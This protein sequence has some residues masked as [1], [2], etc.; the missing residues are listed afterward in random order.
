MAGCCDEDTVVR[1]AAGQRRTLLIVLAINIA[2]FAV[3]FTAGWIAASSALLADSLDMLGDALVYGFSLAVLQRGS[4]WKAVSAAVKGVVMLVFGLLVL[5]RTVDQVLTGG[6]PVSLII[7]LVALLA[8]AGN[9]LCLML[10]TRH[11]G[12]D[13]NMRSTWTCS[14]NDLI[15]NSGVLVAAGGVAATGSHWPD[16]AVGLVI[17]GLFLRSSLGVLGDARASLRGATAG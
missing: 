2:L 1:Q 15:A 8:L 5:G 6:E 12:D 4:T 13:V 3:E 9:S 16:T 10:L 11:R 14:R 7:A 17:A